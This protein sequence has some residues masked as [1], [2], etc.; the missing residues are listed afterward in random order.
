MG[1][2]DSILGCYNSADFSLKPT[3]KALLLGEEAVYLEQVK[4][5]TKYSQTQVVVSLKKG[6]VIVNGENL[7]IK[8]FC[9]GDVALCGKIK[10][11]EIV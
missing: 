8:K 5:I 10:S 1:F 4:Q 9:M 11:I 3:F 6:G 7:S 2:L